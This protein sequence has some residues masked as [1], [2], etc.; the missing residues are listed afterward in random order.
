MGS[1]ASMDSRDEDHYSKCQGDRD[2]GMEVSGEERGMGIRAV[3]LK[4][5]CIF[6]TQGPQGPH[7]HTK[8]L[9]QGKDTAPMSFSPYLPTV[10]P[11]QPH[12]TR[13]QKGIKQP[14]GNWTLVPSEGQKSE[15]ELR[16]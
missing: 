3:T 11:T 7:L 8:A 12:E 13:V 1:S 14:E 5:R 15:E 16:E 6:L 9:L 10:P 4:T 2:G